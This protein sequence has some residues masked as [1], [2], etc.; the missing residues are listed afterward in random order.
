MKITALAAPA[1]DAAATVGNAPRAWLLIDDRP[2]HRTQVVGLARRLGLAVTEKRLSFNPAN[3]LPNALLGATLATLD[4]ARCDPLEPPFP[5][6][7]IGMGR[8]VA[9]VARWIRRASGGAARVVLLGRKAAN[10]S[11]GIDLGV[12]CAHFGLLPHPRLVE[13]VVP[14]T[15]VD[16][17]VLAEA[18]AAR[19]DPL[20]GLARPRVVL[21][22]GGPTAQHRLG[23]DLAARMAREVAEA[24]AALGG[25]LAIVTSRRTPDA[26]VAAIRRAAPHAHLH[27]WRRDRAD[28]P[29]LS[30]L[31]AADLLVVT[32][33]SE[34]MLAEAAATGRP[35]TIYPL[36]PRRAGPKPRLARRIR[37]AADGAGLAGR[38]CRVALGGGWIAP[39]RDVGAMHRRMVARGLAAMFDGTIST[40]A[41]AACDD[42]DRLAGRIAAMLAEAVRVAQ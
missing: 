14:P 11:R 34:S 18:R 25:A 4:R 2:G 7:V 36:A 40:A 33:E 1:E 12:S 27:V 3:R 26:A 9:P 13:L 16:A 17:A 8:R 28:N 29:Y 24:A 19:P 42:A 15:Q 6:L 35:L 37:R 41:P 31:A 10:D 5:D 22:V 23:P 39:P 20:A 21:L 32:G 38:V 30:Y